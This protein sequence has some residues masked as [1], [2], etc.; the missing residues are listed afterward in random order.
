MDGHPDFTS[1]Y[2][3]ELGGFI[4]ILHIILSVCT[5]H[6]LS[7]GTVI[8]YC[9]CQSAI[10]RLQKQSYG[11]LKDF[12]VAAFD[13]LNEGRILL[14]CLKDTT[15]VTISWV[16]GHNNGDVKSMPHLLDKEVH[17]LANKFLHQNLGYYNPSKTVLDLFLSYMT[18][19]PSLQN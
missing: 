13:L 19:P 12:L 14:K 11:S 10:N 9:D 7:G 3:A 2:R 17:N 1:A 6:Q 16:K 8:I 4:A 15:Q 18:I 5:Y